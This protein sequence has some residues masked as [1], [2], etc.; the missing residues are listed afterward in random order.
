MYNTD[1]QKQAN[2]AI[3]IFVIPITK[4]RDFIT[5]SLLKTGI[6]PN[7][8]T[9]LGAIFSLIGAYFLYTG[10]D[11]RWAD[12]GIPDSFYAGI[13]LILACAMDMLDGNLARMGNCKSVFGGILDSS[14]DRISDMAIFGGIAIA[15]ARIGN[16]T[17]VLLSLIALCNAV[18][19]SYIKARAECEPE[20]PKGT[21][22][23][24]YWQRGERM[25]A[26]LIS[27]FAG[28]ITTLVLMLSTLSALTALR[29]GYYSWLIANGKPLP[30]EGGNP[31]LFWRHRRGSWPFVIIS[32]IYILTLAFVDIPTFDF[33][34]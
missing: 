14:L 34:K 10:A 1:N 32:A 11:E 9:I 15:Y 20:I 30:K 24:G 28:H 4:L 29:R 22:S 16:F 5:L 18:M 7:V 31:I 2:I 23:V 33:L 17:F 12:K 21:L 26:I 6:S 25:V 3:R 27:C 13:F 19:I 8:L